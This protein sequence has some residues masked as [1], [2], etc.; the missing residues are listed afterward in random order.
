MTVGDKDVAVRRDDNVRRRIEGI[1]TV[2][3]H[4]RLAERH[5]HAAVRGKVGNG[6]LPAVGDPQGAVGRGEQAVR[7]IE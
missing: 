6:L 2:A 7:P 4:A 1:G 5:Q 3:G